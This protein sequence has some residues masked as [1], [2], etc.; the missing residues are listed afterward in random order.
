M[1]NSY[2][3]VLE[4]VYRKVLDIGF[5][6]VYHDEFLSDGDDYTFSVWDKRSGQIHPTSKNAVAVMGS[7]VLLSAKS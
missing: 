5:D 4:A 6:G 7:I 3:E 2:G 1:T